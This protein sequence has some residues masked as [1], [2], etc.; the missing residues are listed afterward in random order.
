MKHKKTIVF[1]LFFLFSSVL[2][3]TVQSTGLFDDDC[4]V[5][6]CDNENYTMNPSVASSV[7]SVYISDSWIRF[8]NTDFN[9]TSTNP[10][11]ISL[12]Y[13]N[14]NIPAASSGDTVLS[15]SANSSGGLV[16]F[17]ISGFKPNIDYTLYRDDAVVDTYTTDN[18]GILYF[19]NNVWSEHTFKVLEGDVSTDSDSSISIPSV[20]TSFLW[21][22]IFV[23]VLGSMLMSVIKIVEYW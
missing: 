21:I 20:T 17:N 8:N 4:V 16:Y 3:V 10:I 5:F 11:N 2:T 9:I 18:N 14:S 15:F 19:T 7:N 6:N 13:L 22:L 23:T 12:S 1:V